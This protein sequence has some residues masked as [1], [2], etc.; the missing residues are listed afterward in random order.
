MPARRSL[1][2]K[3]FRFDVGRL[4]NSYA[5][6]TNYSFG[7]LR[8]GHTQCLWNRQNE[9]ARRIIEEDLI[10]SLPTGLPG[11]LD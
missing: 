2:A 4:T 10:G 8:Q 1:R 3:G 11:C 7:Y 5:N 6:P 9:Q